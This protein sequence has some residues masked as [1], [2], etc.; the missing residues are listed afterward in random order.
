MSHHRTR[1]QREA[2]QLDMDMYRLAD[3]IEVLANNHVTDRQDKAGLLADASMLRR[4]RTAVRRIM[5]PD[6]RVGTA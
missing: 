4:A 6:D 1:A 5:H 2:N 3:R